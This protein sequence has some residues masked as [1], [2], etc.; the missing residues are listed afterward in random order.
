M[1]QTKKVIIT[2][3]NQSKIKAVENAFL[4]VFPEQEFVFESVSV[5]SDVSDQPLTRAETLQGAKNR[6]Q[7]ALNIIQGDFY[8]GLEGGVEFEND[9][10]FC[11][12]F[13]VVSD[14]VKTGVSQTATFMLP[15]KIAELI[16]QGY[17]LGVA[18]DMFFGRE[19]SKKTNGSIGLLTNDLITRSQKFENAIIMALIPFVK[20]ELYS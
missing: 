14:G 1:S 9:D 7:N 20:P 18:D 15:P 13:A 16:K 3:S 8:V 10:L 2:S 12:G 5:Q 4:K 17:E 6:V 11:F 19:N